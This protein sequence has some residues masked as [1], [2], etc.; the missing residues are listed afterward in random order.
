MSNGKK[1]GGLM[2]LIKEQEVFHIFIKVIVKF[3][4]VEKCLHLWVIDIY[5]SSV[6]KN[7]VLGEV[8][9]LNIKGNLLTA[10]DKIQLYF[11]V[12][13]HQ[14]LDLTII[15][16]EFQKMGYKTLKEKLIMMICH[17]V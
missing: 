11:L 2:K 7:G 6:D 14:G 3:F 5:Y 1:C 17:R 16:L 10:E 8:K 4:S 15:L 13:I 9:T 12:V